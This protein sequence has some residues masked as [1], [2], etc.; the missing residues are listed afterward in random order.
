MSSEY[1]RLNKDIPYF[2]CHIGKIT[3]NYITT[4]QYSLEEEFGDSDLSNYIIN[5]D[6]YTDGS[7]VYYKD[8]II[9]TIQSFIF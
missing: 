9:F 5:E 1:N 3:D 8:S 4:G 7:A 6:M 2:D